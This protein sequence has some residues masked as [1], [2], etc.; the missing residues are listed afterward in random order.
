MTPINVLWRAALAAL[1]LCLA[2]SVDARDPGQVRAFRKDHP[3]P[4][5]GGIRGACPGWVVDH[6]MPLCAGGPDHPRNMQWQ[7]KSESLKKDKLEWELCRHLRKG[8]ACP[9]SI[10][11]M[12][13]PAD[14]R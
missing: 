6:I 3:C 12:P 5:T 11:P 4:L 7:A 10:G 13:E 8:H 14:I 1:F 9:S 2:A